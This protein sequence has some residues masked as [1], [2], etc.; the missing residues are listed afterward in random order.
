MTNINFE[1][2]WGDLVWLTFHW[3]QNIWTVLLGRTWTEEEEEH[4]GHEWQTHAVNIGNRGLEL[5]DLET[6]Q[7]LLQ[8]CTR[9]SPDCF[10][11]LPTSQSSHSLEPCISL[12]TWTLIC[13]TAPDKTS[14]RLGKLGLKH[15]LEI[16]DSLNWPNGLEYA[17][18]PHSVQHTPSC[19]YS[20]SWQAAILVSRHF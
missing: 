11:D 10:L 18:A 3:T 12:H 1:R 5:A 20:V 14:D 2:E 17:A 16:T 9:K 8:Q 6:N 19:H 4:Q 13:I 15:S 7:L